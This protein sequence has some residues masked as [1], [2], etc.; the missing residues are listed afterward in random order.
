MIS[1][2]IP[3]ILNLLFAFKNE[4]KLSTVL[5]IPFDVSSGIKY[6][7]LAIP[8]SPLIENI[9]FRISVILFNKLN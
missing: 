7:T 3:L 4:M 2:S 6:S 9:N 1:E 5:N 8:I